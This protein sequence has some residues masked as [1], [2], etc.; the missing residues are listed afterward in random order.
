MPSRLLHPLD[1]IDD[2]RS[3]SFAALDRTMGRI[4][5]AYVAGDLEAKD[6]AEASLAALLGATMGLADMLGRRRLLLEMDKKLGRKF[7]YAASTATP[8]I[9]KVPFKQAIKILAER[10]PRLAFSAE[11]VS[12]LYAQEH[13]FAMARSCSQTLTD[14][15][16]EILVKQMQSGGDALRAQKRIVKLSEVMQAT[17]P[18]TLS[19]A[20]L[21]YR[22]ALTDSYTAGRFKLA[23]DPDVAEYMVGFRFDAVGD[24]DTTTWCKA[25]DGLMAATNDPIWNRCSPIVHHGC[26]STLTLMSRD[27]FKAAGMVGRDGKIKAA[28]M[29]PGVLPFAP[30]FGM[31]RPD[32]RL[33]G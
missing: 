27:D 10:D 1:E 14:R 3:R 21:V 2:L 29:P 8:L 18:F 19:Y 22:N 16:Q 26:R 4:V 6:R 31:G 32:R 15:V 13:V 20:T 24:G 33:H 9:P 5:E 25:L 30:G 7:H 17:K 28:K 12:E 11:E 23:Q